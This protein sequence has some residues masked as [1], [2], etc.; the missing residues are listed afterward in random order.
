MIVQINQGIAMGKRQS[1]EKLIDII[2]EKAGNNTVMFYRNSFAMSCY[3]INQGQT[4]AG[5]KQLSYLF[6]VLG[7][8]KRSTYFSAIANSIEEFPDEYASEIRANLEINKLF[9]K[10]S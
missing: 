8:N 2:E 10:L 5:K 7:R 1:L 9:Y 6:D 3:L 4:K